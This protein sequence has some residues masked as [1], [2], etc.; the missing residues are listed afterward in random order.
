MKKEI[1]I[2]GALAAVL[3]TANYMMQEIRSRRQKNELLEI[4]DKKNSELT[5]APLIN[6]MTYKTLNSSS[7]KLGSYFEDRL[8]EWNSIIIG[9]FLDY[10]KVQISDL[11][12][13]ELITQALKT[14]LSNKSAARVA[15]I[16]IDSLNV[17]FGQ[18]ESSTFYRNAILCKDFTF[19]AISENDPQKKGSLSN[20]EIRIAIAKIMKETQID[21]LKK[22]FFEVEL[23]KLSQKEEASSEPK[24][25]TNKLKSY[26]KRNK[27]II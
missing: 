27:K 15:K 18:A 9:N 3:F 8:N 13:Y 7:E 17:E 21:E 10:L 1:K 22:A 16:I 2:A 11:K 20:E 14:A 23:K 4:L 6:R 12:K 5:M 26:F 19:K 25:L 24:S